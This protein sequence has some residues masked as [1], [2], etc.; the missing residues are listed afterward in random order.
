MSS[1]ARCKIC[2]QFETL[3]TK[4]KGKSKQ[5][6]TSM[7][8]HLTSRH[9]TECAELISP[10]VQAAAKRQPA[11]AAAFQKMAST[12]YA[13]DSTHYTQRRALVNEFI[14]A[15]S[16]APALLEQP[17]FR[18]L[19]KA[20]DPRFSPHSR[21][22]FTL[23]DVPAMESFLKKE[24]MDNLAVSYGMS[25]TLDGWTCNGVPF[26]A[27]TG[28]YIMPQ[29]TSHPVLKTSLLALRHFPDSHTSVNI[30]VLVGAVLDDY[31]PEWRQKNM[32]FCA[33]TDSASNMVSYGKSDSHSYTW[34]RCCAHLLNLTV[35]DFFSKAGV[36]TVLEKLRVLRHKFKYEKVF[37]KEYEAAAV[38][39]PGVKF[40][41]LIHDVATRWNS[42]LSMMRRALQQRTMITVAL[43][44]L[45]ATE[46]NLSEKEWKMCEALVSI[47]EP[48]HAATEE[49]SSQ[50]KVTISLPIVMLERRLQ[51]LDPGSES[52]LTE[53]YKKLMR[54][55]LE[56]RKKG[57]EGD[58]AV[59]KLGVALDPRF[60]QRKVAL[61]KDT[62][63]MIEM[64]L[65]QIQPALGDKFKP[66][67]RSSAGTKRIH[68]LFGDEQTNTPDEEQSDELL[69]YKMEITPEYEVNPLQWWHE[70]KHK[71]PKL[72]ALAMRVLSA[73]ATE[74]P[75]ERL[76][77]SAGNIF[78][79]SRQSM[80]PITLARLL[81][82][83][84]NHPQL[85]QDRLEAAQPSDS[86]SDTFVSSE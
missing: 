52:E 26:L 47:L 41:R 53:K 59:A 30:D 10:E 24:I 85:Q 4:A 43:A 35:T 19:L 79:V 70:R 9:A 44:R 18:R 61:T 16:Q 42:A 73:Q 75:C 3:Y 17:S 58:G 78:T 33:T 86:D 57:Y 80:L 28:H 31:L 37:S 14:I 51:S 46:L 11:I 54:E 69:A 38:G 36:D 50:T 23:E 5:S 83:N 39:S 62:E 32:V 67:V 64:L 21:K 60:K 65:K 49:V 8:Y 66:I 2:K 77:S 40:R 55:C 13:K 7:R 82:I 56:S 81:F 84:A 45:Q 29:Q 74:V 12:P 25:I 71:L 72:F 6:L 34:I 15:T 22:T 48:F 63:R 20:F 76:F 1:K 68:M 27:I